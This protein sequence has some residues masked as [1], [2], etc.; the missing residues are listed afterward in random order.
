MDIHGFLCTDGHI[1]CA[2]NLM[3][4]TIYVRQI[5]SVQEVKHSHS[6]DAEL[7]EPGN[8]PLGGVYINMQMTN[9][10]EFVRIY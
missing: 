8:A 4:R 3:V 1:G 10:V 6:H 2:E 9:S 5:R 7:N